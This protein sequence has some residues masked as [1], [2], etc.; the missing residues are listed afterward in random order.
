MLYFLL[1]A[2]FL[3]KGTKLLIIISGKYSQSYLTSF[4][5]FSGNMFHLYCYYCYHHCIHS[6][7]LWLLLHH[8]LS[9]ALRGT[10]RKADFQ[11]ITQKNKICK[12][13]TSK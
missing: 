10:G 11:E 12:V 2:A 8:L 6:H 7:F 9:S 13:I 1:S 3:W 4:S 5:A